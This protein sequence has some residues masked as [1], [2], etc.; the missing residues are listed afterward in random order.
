M[1]RGLW[2]W[3]PAAA[4]VLVRLALWLWG[5]LYALEASDLRL[6]TVEYHALGVSLSEGRGFVYDEPSY[7]PPYEVATLR[8]PGYPALIASVYAWPGPRP[9][10]VLLLQILLDAASCALLAWTVHPVLSE[11][12][13]AVAAL[14]LALHPVAALYSQTLLNESLF[15]FLLVGAFALLWGPTRRDPL[16]W[17]RVAGAGGTLGLAILVK[18]FALWM[19]PLM[20]AVWVWTQGLGRLPVRRALALVGVAAMVVAPWVARN[21]VVHD[22]AFLSTSGAYNALALYAA[23]VEA[24]VTGQTLG[25]ATR[26]L[27]ARA[28]ERA[29]ESG[30][31]GAEAGD[32]ARAPFWREEAFAVLARHPVT[33]VE[34]ETKGLARL[35]LSIGRVSRQQVIGE[36]E[37]RPLNPGVSGALRWWA[38]EPLQDQVLDVWALLAALTLYPL[39]LVGVVRAV[40]HRKGGLVL[41]A[42][43]LAAFFVLT[44]AIPG[45]SRFLLPALPFLAVVA[46]CAVS[47]LVGSPGT[48]D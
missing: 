27:L 22:R 39:M 5:G 17:R 31:L 8:T 2:L 29:R 10:W 20:A 42:G 14:V 43:G 25:D 36:R 46:G 11:R 23:P 9:G 37:A 13:G 40:R 15:V 41:A 7:D 35:F 30:R 45:Y 48:D 26:A 33:V 16:R 21:A 24:R 1:R 28:E 4:A 18:P 32:L 44:T 34:L 38:A 19:V 3:S 6:D 12:G 47:P